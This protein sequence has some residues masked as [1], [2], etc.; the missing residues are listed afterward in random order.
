MTEAKTKPW[1]IVPVLLFTAFVGIAIWALMKGPS[2]SHIA[3]QGKPIPAFSLPMLGGKTVTEDDLRGRLTLVNFFA[4]WCVPCRAENDFF[5]NLHAEGLQRVG[6]A[7]KDK[8]EDLDNFLADQNPYD[9]VGMDSEG[10][11]AIDFGV[12]GVPETFLVGPDLTVLAFHAG[13]LTQDVW[14]REFA[15]VLA[16]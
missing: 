13:P 16:K 5:L 10:K 11:V 12:A 8:K 15:P 4:S 6:I 14:D 2:D 1:L 3:H 7:Y 9:R